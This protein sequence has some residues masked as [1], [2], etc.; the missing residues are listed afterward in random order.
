M[1]ALLGSGETGR[2]VTLKT[3][4]TRPPILGVEEAQAM[5]K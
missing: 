5:L 3:R 1:L 2:F 4:C